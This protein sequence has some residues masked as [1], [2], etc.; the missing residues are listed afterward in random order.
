MYLTKAGELFWEEAMALDVAYRGDIS[1]MSFEEAVAGTGQS[2]FMLP[3]TPEKLDLTIYARELVPAGN[4]IFPSDVLTRLL[5]AASAPVLYTPD[6]MYAI[7]LPGDGP[8]IH[9]ALCSFRDGWVQAGSRFA[10]FDSGVLSND[11]IH[12]QLFAHT[13]GGD[14][15]LRLNYGSQMQEI[16]LT[17]TPGWVEAY[18][19][20]EGN[21]PA[22]V[23]FEG[24]GGGIYVESYLI[25]GLS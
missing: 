19:T 14:A 22:I 2:G 13:D 4:L 18:F 1:I 7:V 5:P 8:W 16:P 12:L 25:Q 6:K 9:S 17:A 11:Q 24:L 20:L 15:V 23:D 21:N 10:L 3:F